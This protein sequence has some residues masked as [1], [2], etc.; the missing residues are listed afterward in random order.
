MRFADTRRALLTMAAYSLIG[1]TVLAVQPMVVGALVDLLHFSPRQAG[2]VASAEL[3]GFSAAGIA[4]LWVVQRADRRWLALSGVLLVV[5]ADLYA[6]TVRDFG[7]MVVVRVLAGAGAA[8]AYSIFPLLAASSSRPERIFGIINASS[9]GYAG[10]FVWLAP[11]LLALCALPGIFV[12]MAVLALAVS[13]SIL[14][15]PPVNA[16]SAQESHSKTETQEAAAAN[17]AQGASLGPITLLLSATL[18]LYIGHGSIWAYQERIGVAAGLAAGQVGSLLGSSMLLWGVAGSLLATWLGLVFGRIWPQLLALV[19]SIV[20]VLLLIYG[21]QPVT[22]GVACALVAL[23]W[24]YGLPYLAGWLAALDKL[25][26]ANIACM[27]VSTAGSA[28][29]PA[30]AAQLIGSRQNYSAIASLA[31]S[32]YV[33]CAVFVAITGLLLRA[34]ASDSQSDLQSVR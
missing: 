11:R 21:G 34:T 24:F 6:C 27:L 30:L 13:A 31:G 20:A 22:Y 17:G 26:R 2:L 32:C 18:C 25:G 8:I 29:G 19:T 9:I 5:I 1:N 10:L 4:M 28:A 12:A 15:V 7:A 16:C 23:S 33:L 14:W 3:S